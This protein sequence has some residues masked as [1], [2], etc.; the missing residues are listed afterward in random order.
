VL[1]IGWSASTQRVTLCG[2]LP[3][4]VV[5]CL[6]E[7][8]DVALDRVARAITIHGPTCAV[9]DQSVSCWSSGRPVVTFDLAGRRDLAGAVADD[10]YAVCGLDDEGRVG[11]TREDGAASPQPAWLP[12]DVHLRAL[13]RPTCAIAMTGTLHCEDES[14]LRPYAAEIASWQTLAMESYL[15]TAGRRD[16][17]VTFAA[18]IGLDRR[19][20]TAGPGFLGELGDG[21]RGRAGTARI[22]T[23]GVGEVDELV[24][25]ATHV[26]VRKGGRVACWGESTLGQVSASARATIPTCSVDHASS[27]R[28]YRAHLRGERAAFTQCMRRVCRQPELDCRLG[29]RAARA[30]S[31]TLPPEEYVYVQTPEGC[32]EQPTPSARTFEPSPVFFPGIGDARQVVV[33]SGV[34]CVLRESGRTR[35]YG[36]LS[37]VSI[38]ADGVPR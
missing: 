27:L 19:V 36:T 3:T 5:R 17:Y 6:G 37:G 2:A 28:A 25:S 21:T 18:G 9:L 33:A 4:G 35:C 32:L 14:T 10:A 22:D 26:C 23:L 12:A 29:C 24:V 38:A 34:T 11:C 7:L 1:G 13:G 31:P 16:A 30:E 20:H 15:R 8:P